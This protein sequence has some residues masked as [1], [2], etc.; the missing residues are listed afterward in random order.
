M[1]GCGYL[2][3]QEGKSDHCPLAL[4]VRLTLFS[5]PPLIEKPGKHVAPTDV[6]NATLSE[7]EMAFVIL[8]V[9]QTNPEMFKE[10]ST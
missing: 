6:M 4:H 8:S 1:F 10:I 3:L 2:R 9:G 5:F 7:L